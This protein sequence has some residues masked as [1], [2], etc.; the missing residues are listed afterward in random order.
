MTRDELKA[1]EGMTDAQI[2][3]VIALYGRD[4]QALTAE[5]QTLQTQITGLQGQLTTAQSGM[6]A[7][8][9]MTA[10]QAVQKISELQN[11]MTAQEAKYQFDTRLR[12]AARAAGAL[13]EDDVITLL[14]GK[15]TLQAS[16]EQDKD[17]KAAIDGL[18]STKAYLFTTTTP[19]G[20]GDPASGDQAG[21]PTTPQGQQPQTPPTSIVTPKPRT[22]AGSDPKLADFIDMSGI[23]R[24]EL[25]AKNPTLF[26]ALIK[27]LQQ[28]R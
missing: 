21:K 2:N 19:E 7:L 26:A 23:Q 4:T 18:K 13:S 14:P 1:I 16:K 5:R 9:G 12:A 15:D 24:M 22:P 28:R 27:E 11:Q 8:H 25:R 17:I 3:A 6:A 10:E 20:E